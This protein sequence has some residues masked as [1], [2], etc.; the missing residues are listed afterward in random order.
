MHCGKRCCHAGYSEC[1]C[2]GTPGL[3]K[4]SEMRPSSIYCVIWLW[5]ASALP[6]ALAGFRLAIVTMWDGSP[7]YACAVLHWCQHAQR[8]AESLGAVGAQNRSQI[9]RQTIAEDCPNIHVV[10]PD[11]ELVAAVDIFARIAG[12]NHAGSCLARLTSGHAH[13]SCSMHRVMFKLWALSLH[14]HAAVLFADLD[15]Q[16]MRPEASRALTARAWSR[17]WQRMR[18]QNPRRV[19]VLSN[20]DFSFPFNAGLMSV[21]WPAYGGA[22]LYRTALSL[23]A[24]VTWNA[25]LGFSTPHIPG[26]TPR[27]LYDA[28]KSLRPRLNGSLPSNPTYRRLLVH[29][30][31]RFLLQNTWAVSGGD[32]DQGFLFYVLYVLPRLRANKT[33]HVKGW[34]EEAGSAIIGADHPASGPRHLARHYAGGA[35]PWIR[36]RTNPAARRARAAFY[37]RQTNLSA[38]GRSHCAIKLARWA[39]ELPSPSEREPFFSSWEQRVI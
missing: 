23:M 26:V 25:T 2:L 36:L 18:A 29:A 19:H 14:E 15:V 7:T 20:P 21:L 22:E 5:P 4:H 10:Q 32:C 13:S 34:R 30:P 39:A 12:C 9:A 11:A 37:L 27:A 16:I 24:N 6:M 38:H 17:H 1:S 33:A 8:L 31:S 3:W 28:F 35:K